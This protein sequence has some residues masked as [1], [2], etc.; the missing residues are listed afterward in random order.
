L[1]TQTLHA[2]AEKNQLSVQTL[3]LTAFAETVATWSSSSQFR[4][5]LPFFV[6]APYQQEIDAVV[7][8]FANLS[9]LSVE[10]NAQDVFYQA[11]QRIEQQ[12]SQVQAHAAYAGIHV[13]RDLSKHRQQLET[14]PIVFTSA[15]EIGE[16][17]SQDVQLNL[18]RPVWCISQGPKVDLD[19]QIAYMNGGLVVNWDI[20]R[21]AFKPHV[22]QHMFEHYI[23]QITAMLQ[24]ETYLHS[25]M[26]YQLPADQQ[27][28]RQAQ[29]AALAAN[30]SRQLAVH[31]DEYRVVNAMGLDCPDWVIGTLWGRVRTEDVEQHNAL[32]LKMIQGQSWYATGYAAYYNDAAEIVVF[33]DR[34]QLLKMHG[35]WLDLNE[36]RQKILDIPQLADAKVYAVDHD[37]KTRFIAYLV[38]SAHAELT[39]QQLHAAY[40]ARLP[41]Y[42]IPEHSYVV[43]A[44]QFA[45]LN[46]ENIQEFIKNNQSLAQHSSAQTQTALE[47][48][49]YFMMAKIIGLPPDE[50][51]TNIDFFDYGGD[52]LLA[53]H[54][55]AAL[56][57]YFK[58]CG[59][60]VVDIFTQRTVKNIAQII[61]QNLPQ[62][63]HKIAEIFL[64]V[65][66]GKK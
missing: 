43:A 55:V 44:E 23:A 33:E 2:I 61:E 29:P 12:V 25:P 10:L 59:I 7:G 22:I 56:H 58:D 39:Q 26:T 6:R 16:I 50:H 17:F 35:Y 37:G 53:T 48:V 21:H 5:N 41:H 1:D 52:S 42:L 65:L 11:A 20:R 31:C 18:G 54:F 8:D 3:C 19:V 62:S 32:N 9:L 57:R 27:V 30:V 13:L 38:L 14:S 66:E 64:K 4:L 15:L 36:I 51:N 28:R 63:A 47:Q 60:T 24:D 46:A 34:Q 49:V 45:Q 40:A